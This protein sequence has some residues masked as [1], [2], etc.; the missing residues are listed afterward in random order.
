MRVRTATKKDGSK[1]VCMYDDH[2]Y[3]H[4]DIVICDCDVQVIADDTK[5][6]IVTPM[7]G[8]AKVTVKGTADKTDIE[9]NNEARKIVESDY[10]YISK[11]YPPDF[12]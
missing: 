9:L 7:L 1:V 6:V 4:G 2:G 10:N 3:Y 11:D 8:G 12:E 5:S